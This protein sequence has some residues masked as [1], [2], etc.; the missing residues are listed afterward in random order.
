[1][2]EIDPSHVPVGLMSLPTELREMILSIVM[3][4]A[5]LQIAQAVR[6][7]D[8]DRFTRV[9]LPLVAINKQCRQEMTAVL[10]Q[11]C[12]FL[13]D[14]SEQLGKERSDPYR[15]V[16]LYP[17]HIH[18]LY[19]TVDCSSLRGHVTHGSAL[20]KRKDWISNLKR[21]QDAFALLSEDHIIE[22]IES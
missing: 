17:I 11:H 16:E 20:F 19:D 13:D 1:M 5:C 7:I 6:S 10:Q 2:T 8:K 22:M 12:K 21:T 9:S 14:Y 4:E 15:F 18:V 3:A